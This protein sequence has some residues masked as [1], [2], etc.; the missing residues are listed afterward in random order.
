MRIS[1]K[2]TTIKH[3][4]TMQDHILLDVQHHP[5]LGLEIASDL[6]WSHQVDQ[7]KA[8][9][10]RSLNLLWRNVRKC[11]QSTREAAYTTLV[12]P[13]LEYGSPVWDPFQGKH[14]SDLEQVQR[15]AARYVCQDYSRE[16]SVTTMLRQLE[17]ESL[18]QR[19]FTARMCIMYKATHDLI[20]VPIPAYFIPRS[21]GDHSFVAIHTRI[22]LYKYSFFPC[23]IRWW[24]YL[25][26]TILEAP[27]INT[28]RE[29]L[30]KSLSCGQIVLQR[31][32]DSCQSPYM[33]PGVRSLN[34]Y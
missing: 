29:R 15:R 4:Y 27:S 31:P 8:K 5:Y 18:Q 20:A 13:H 22:D 1:K 33:G 11:P 16:S 19:R 30:H 12:R 23:T 34:M 28:F 24:N 21:K 32:K 6:S 10:T 3:N 2:R 26:A 17:W 14:I 25:P 9:A 7:M